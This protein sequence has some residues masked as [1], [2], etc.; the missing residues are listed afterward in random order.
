MLKRHIDADDAIY[1][2]KRAFP[3]DDFGKII[4]C[5][6]RTPTV[7]VTERKKGKWLWTDGVRCSNCNHK[8]QTT[9]LPSYCPHCEASMREESDNERTDQRI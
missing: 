6:S 8:L 5:I 7:D 1:E 9:G 4:R 2:L 3:A